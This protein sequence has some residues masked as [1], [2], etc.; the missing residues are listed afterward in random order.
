[1]NVLVIAAHPDDEV[2][3][4]GAT[5]AGLARKGDSVTIAVLGE[6]ATS[7]FENREQADSALTDDLRNASERAAELLGANNLYMS[8][9]PDN[10]FDTVALLDVVKI[11][12]RLIERHQPEVILCH[13]GADLN[14]DHT[15]A[16]RAT[17]TATRPVPGS[18][19]RAVYAFEVPSSTE[20]AF[21]ATGER[22][23]PQA[24]VDVT[25]TLDVKLAAMSIYESE[26]RPFPHPRSPQALAALARMR[27][28]QA[29]FDAAEAFQLIRR[30]GL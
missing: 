3:G 7:R 17:L 15:V 21:G 5:V 22:F 29:G 27:G 28:A 19:V 12:E 14:V 25:D 1:M 24:F 20:W 10:R 2:L 23:N 16:F 8:G 11:V 18:T 4:C 6:G 13:H 30:Q 9:L 26:A